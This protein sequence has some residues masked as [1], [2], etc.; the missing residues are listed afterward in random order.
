[1]TTV[2]R[3]N[4]LISLPAFHSFLALP[5]LKSVFPLYYLGERTRKYQWGNIKVKQ[6]FKHFYDT[7]RKVDER[8]MLN[9]DLWDCE[10]PFG[11]I[12]DEM[13]NVMHPIYFRLQFSFFMYFLSYLKR[14]ENLLALP[15]NKLHTLFRHCTKMTKNIFPSIR[16]ICIAIHTFHCFS[17]SSFITYT[18][19]HGV[20]RG[21]SQII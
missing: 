5:S 3:K 9:E 16:L 4:V 17:F 18:K 15:L 8:G 7:P 12:W 2:S 20:W 10:I 1:M 6:S 11:T 14:F 13:L 19:A 21:I